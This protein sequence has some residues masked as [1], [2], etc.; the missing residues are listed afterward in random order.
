MTDPYVYEGSSVL[1]NLLDITE[2]RTLDLVE[3]EQSR[4]NMMLL[5]EAGFNDFS[6]PGI[7]YLH[8]YLFGDIYEWAGQFRVINIQKREKILAGASVWY[9][10]V[11]SIKEDLDIVWR[12]IL[13][14][15][16]PNLTRELF[17]E[18]LV[19]HFPLLWKVHPFREGNTRT[20]VMMMTFFIEN[21]GYYVD[22]ELLVASA[23]YVRNAF[24]LAAINDYAEREHLKA[25]LLDA[26]KTDPI[27][28]TAID[29]DDA[30]EKTSR[31]TQY[32]TEDYQPVAHEVR[33]EQYDPEKYRT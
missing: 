5:Y 18:Q 30:G 8:K 26:I 10:N 14:I 16:W 17:V 1:K 32:Q 3:A 6:T 19:N 11:D 24:V 31:C 22:Q 29:S 2:S 33:R 23:G 21:H 27:E 25:I 12:K 7:Q 9:S 13:S 15:D 28:Y 20:I 4:A